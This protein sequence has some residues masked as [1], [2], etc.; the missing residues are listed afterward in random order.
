MNNNTGLSTIS[1]SAG[2]LIAAMHGTGNGALAV[3]KPYCDP[4]CLVPDTRVAGTTHVDK[5]DELASGLSTGDKLRLERDALNHH[6]QWAIRVLD[7]SNNRIGFVPADVNEIPARL[8]D[9]GK[10]L[11][12]QITSIEQRGSWWRIGMGVWLDD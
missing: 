5:I 10:R 11:F 8:M 9:G 3:P 2:A 12:G 6:N 7:A 4:I 1:T